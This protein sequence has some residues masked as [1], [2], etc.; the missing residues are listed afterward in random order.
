VLAWLAALLAAPLPPA[1]DIGRLRPQD[2]PPAWLLRLQAPDPRA[3][4]IVSRTSEPLQLTISPRVGIAPLMVTIRLRLPEPQAPD[5]ELEITAWDAADEDMAAPLF[6]STRDLSW[7]ADSGPQTHT[8][9]WELPA[10][11]V[12]VVGCVWPRGA[13]VGQRVVVG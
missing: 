1:P 13:C 6:R 3:R 8:A 12:L 10:G 2:I 11:E 7:R 4:A 5:K 9:R